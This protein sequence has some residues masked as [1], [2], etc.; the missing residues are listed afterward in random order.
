MVR[1]K[2]VTFTNHN[3][4]AVYTSLRSKNHAP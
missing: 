1:R 3:L 2:V 4:S